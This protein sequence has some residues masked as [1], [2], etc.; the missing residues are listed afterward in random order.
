MIS[1]AKAR[2]LEALEAGP[3]EWKV[4]WLAGS[5]NPE[6][7]FYIG[8]TQ[9]SP[10]ERLRKHRQCNRHSKVFSR[11]KSLEDKG[12]RALILVLQDGLTIA[13]AGALE[14][15]LIKTVGRL[16]PLLNVMTYPNTPLSW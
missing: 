10:S 9:Q 7:P 13:Q 8:Q 12:F 6:Q 1:E 15:K 4:Y 2:Y 16:A 5:D 3:T 11:I 14:A